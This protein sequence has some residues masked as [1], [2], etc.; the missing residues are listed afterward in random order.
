VRELRVVRFEWF[1]CDLDVGILQCVAKCDECIVC[2]VIDRERVF[3]VT[4]IV[5]RFDLFFDRFYWYVE[6]GWVG[7]LDGL[8]RKSFWERP[9]GVIVRWFA[10]C[11][12]ICFRYR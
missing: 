8:D 4:D 5:W 3:L 2:V 9:F 10:V 12:G 11:V 1:F 6:N 7:D